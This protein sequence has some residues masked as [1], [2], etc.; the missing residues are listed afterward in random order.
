M[1]QIDIYWCTT[2]QGGSFPLK[3]NNDTIS[4]YTFLCNTV[5]IN[6]YTYDN[7]AT[8]AQ[9]QNNPNAFAVAFMNCTKP[10]KVKIAEPEK[11]ISG[12]NVIDP[13]L[14]EQ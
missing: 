1:L 4:S 7:F 5:L 2:I 10:D 6:Q 11:E 8:H 3:H 13:T 12:S 9:I 14:N